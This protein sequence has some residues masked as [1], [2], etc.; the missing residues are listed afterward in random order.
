VIYTE[1]N[2]V[3]EGR[4]DNKSKT[5]RKPDVGQIWIAGVLQNG[6]GL[7]LNGDV[8][9]RLGSPSDKDD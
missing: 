2:S 8:H 1:D 4:G 9:I 5:P 6:D 3:P 7:S